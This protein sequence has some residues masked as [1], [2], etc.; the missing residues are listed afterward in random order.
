[1]LT[2]LLAALWFTAAPLSQDVEATKP[3]IRLSVHT[4]ATLMAGARSVYSL[5]V[6]R[7]GIPHLAKNERDTP[8]FLHART[9]QDRVCAFL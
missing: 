1:V 5:Q 9:G 8:N 3:Q 2:A 6:R 7:C 4:G